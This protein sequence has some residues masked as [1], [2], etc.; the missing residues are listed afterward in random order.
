MYILYQYNDLDYRLVYLKQ[1]NKYPKLIRCFSSMLNSSDDKKE[2]SER[3]SLSRTKRHIREL[4]I[5]NYWDYFGTITVNGSYYD[6][7]SLDVCQDILKKTLK[8]I[9]RSQNEKLHYIIITEK[10][11]DGAFHFHGLFS[12]LDLVTNDNGYFT[13]SELSKIGFCSF[14]PIRDHVKTC[15]YITK[16]IT[17]D[18]V[19]NSHNQIYMRSRGLKLATAHRNITVKNQPDWG[20]ENDFVKIF[21]FSLD[22]LS[23]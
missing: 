22:N 21:D 11:K 23:R 14:S 9:Q 12:N 10:H 8:K 5:C 2:E 20:Y 3:T 17:K 16:Y 7:Y 1:R 13:N 4:A 19:R 18:C 15:N 6:R